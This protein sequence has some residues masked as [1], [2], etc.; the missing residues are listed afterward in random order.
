MV[1][2]E[3]FRVDASVGTF[4]MVHNV[5]A[6]LTIGVCGDEAQKRRLLPDMAS[7]KHVGCWGLTEPD[8]GSDASALA[9]TARKVP[10]G[11]VLNG[12]KRW[13]GNGTWVSAS[14]C[15]AW[16]EGRGV[17]EVSPPLPGRHLLH[18]GPKP[19]DRQDQLV[20]RKDCGRQMAREVPPHPSQPLCLQLCGSQGRQ[21]HDEHQ[22]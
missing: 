7:L 21:G 12:R 15:C 18:L 14:Q 11:W 2:L 17:R 16:G 13:I 19:R 20:R 8:N 1:V 22:D 9:T 4:M 3:M 6:M 5:L 10:G